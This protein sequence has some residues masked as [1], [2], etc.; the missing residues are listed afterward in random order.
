MGRI[1]DRLDELG[2]ELPEPFSPPAGVEFSFD[3][4][5]VSGNYAYVSGHGP[6]D[7]S[8]VLVSGK[9]G[10]EVSL[11]EATEAARLTGL[12]ILTSLRSELG[13]LDRITG[14]VKALGWVDCAPGF[15]RTPAVINGFSGLLLEIWGDAG[16]HARSAVGAS[17]L[18]FG[19][20]VEVEVIAEIDGGTAP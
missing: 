12:S 20:S 19:M 7:G 15:D 2:I 3:L 1:D 14:W 5:R 9:V 6:V 8:R 16:R 11:E 10:D 13:N 18:P 17:A 4:V